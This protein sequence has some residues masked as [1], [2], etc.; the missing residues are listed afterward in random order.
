MSDFTSILLRL[1]QVP[2]LGSVRIQQILAHVNIEDL[3]NYDEV[4]FQQMGWDALQI[5]RWFQPEMKFIEPALSW[6]EK[7]GHHLIHCFSDEYPF[8]LK[9]ISGFPPLLFVKGNLTAL[10]A[11]QIAMVGSRYCSAYGEYWAKYFAT[12][13]SLAGLTV[14]SG[15]ALGIDGFSHQAVVDIQGQTIAVLGSGLEHIYPAKHRRL[16]E[17]IIENN[18]ALVSEFIPTQAPIAENFPRRNRIISGLS[19]GTLVIE[20]TEK[21]G[22]L[23]TARYALEQ[24]RDIFALPGNIQSEYSQGCHKLIKQGAMLVE[25]VKDILESLNHHIVFQPPVKTPINKSI[26]QQLTAKIPTVEPSHPELYQHITYTPISLDDL[27]A[28]LSLSV[29]LLLVLLLYFELHDLIVNENGL[30]KRIAYTG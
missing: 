5:R 7:E 30:Y 19:L 24:N 26:E 6:A 23:I 3:L 10:S 28:A 25:N 13:L 14:T 21:S 4:A 29:D 9:Q 18:G 2:K 17:Q 16:A 15:L 11:Q 1:A 27:S 8:L 12:E 22:S 20:A